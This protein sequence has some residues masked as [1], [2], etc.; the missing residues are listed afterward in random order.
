MAEFNTQKG[1][2][3]LVTLVIGT[4]MLVIIGALV[5]CMTGLLGH[6]IAPDA[7]KDIQK[8]VNE[9]F[10]MAFT[11]AIAFAVGRMS[12]PSPPDIKLPP[13]EPKEK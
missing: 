1:A 12:A 3:L 9:L 13:E 6:Y 10:Q 11:A 8:G 7:C 2:F 5:F 4:Q